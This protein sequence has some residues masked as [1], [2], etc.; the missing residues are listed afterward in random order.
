MKPYLQ[1]R[2]GLILAG[3]LL[4]NV[5]LSKTFFFHPLPERGVV[6]VI[7]HLENSGSNTVT[8]KRESIRLLLENGTRLEPLDSEEV[9]RESRLAMHRAYLGLPLIA[10]YFISRQQI[11][12]FNFG[13]ASDYRRKAL[14]AFL[15]MVPEDLPSARVVFFRLEQENLAGLRSPILEVTVEVEARDQSGSMKPGRGVSFLLALDRQQ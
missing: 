5:T 13:L 3:T 9:I 7:L 10:P 12:E 15:R 2:L 11:S 6:P 8:V 14:P 4:D 1:E